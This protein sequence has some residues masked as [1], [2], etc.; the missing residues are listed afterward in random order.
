MA[1]PPARRAR[2]GSLT[3]WQRFWEANNVDKKQAGRQK[4]EQG[5]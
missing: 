3:G 5:F 1:S 4:I 2:V